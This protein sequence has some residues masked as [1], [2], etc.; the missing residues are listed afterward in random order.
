MQGGLW[1]LVSLMVV[2]LN[3]LLLIVVAPFCIWLIYESYR[4]YYDKYDTY[5]NIEKS[6]KWIYVVFWA[7][8]IFTIIALL[9][10]LV[11]IQPIGSY[12]I[13]DLVIFLPIFA[14]CVIIF[15]LGPLIYLLSKWREEH[16]KYFVING[17]KE[18]FIPR[19]RKEKEERKKVAEKKAIARKKREKKRKE[20]EIEIK[21][22]EATSKRVTFKTKREKYIKG[23]PKEVKKIINEKQNTIIN[24]Y[25]KLVKENSFGQKSYDKFLQEFGDFLSSESKNITKLNELTSLNYLLIS[26]ENEIRL[27][28][29]NRDRYEDQHF[30]LLSGVLRDPIKYIEKII[31]QNDFDIKFDPNMDPFQYEIFCAE[32]FK[33]NDWEAYATQGSSDQGVDVVAK[34]GKKVLVAQCKKFS[35]PVGNKA[36]QEV[37]AGMKF[38]DANA[39]IVI[40]PNGF[41][42]SAEK[43]AAANKIKLI[44]HSQIKDL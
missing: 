27:Y 22:L 23:L 15:S 36:V 30:G 37:V 40:A 28:E 4:E 35:K 24:A 39:G 14:L 32:K 16:Y 12:N 41:T 25:R 1:F 11:A 3:P 10:K 33:E 21:R 38:Y 44:H 2:V 5:G 9:V 19:I 6:W 13:A 18:Q 26:Q 20:K 17:F 31:E 7:S 34:K 42:N 8:L 43:L 29:A